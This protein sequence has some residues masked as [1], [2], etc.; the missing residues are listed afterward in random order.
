MKESSVLSLILINRWLY[1]SFLLGKKKL[2]LVTKLH[3]FV[4]EVKFLSLTRCCLRSRPNNFFKR[5]RNFF[6]FCFRK[7]LIGDLSFN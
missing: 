2:N 4:T 5:F 3:I 7:N 6:R 1:L